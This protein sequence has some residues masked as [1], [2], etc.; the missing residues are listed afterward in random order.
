MGSGSSKQRL[1]ERVLDARKKLAADRKLQSARAALLKSASPETLETIVQSMAAAFKTYSPFSEPALLVAF[2]ANPEETQRILTKACKQVLSAP[3]IREQYEWFIRYVFASSVWMLPAS[4]KGDSFLFQEMMAIAQSM[5]QKIDLSMDSIFKHLASHDDWDK[6]TQIKDQTLVARQ[7]D[8]KVGL[9]RD[10]GITDL[11]NADLKQQDEDEDK[12]EGD[13]LTTFV[14]SNLAVNILTTTAKQLN[15]EF[16]AHIKPVMR[17]Y[18]D[19][20]EGP[21]KT[22]ERCQSKLENEYHDAEYPKAAKLLDLVRCSVSFN[23]LEQLLEGYEGLMRYIQTTSDSLELA[24]VKNGFLKKDVSFRDIKVHVVYHSETDPDNPVSMICEV[25]LI[26]NQYS[27]E[28][29]RIHKLY[30]ILR[31]RTY[32]EM[33]VKGS[34]DTKE[35]T[36]E[37]KDLQF[38]QVLN[39][40]EHRHVA[41]RCA[42]KHPNKTSGVSQ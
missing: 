37:L 7:D 31:E 24:C 40:K 28:K 13:D 8:D 3:I 19:F 17:R 12:Q 6:L 18:G 22:V 20:K 35:Q 23:T 1:G 2:E 15:P 5:S 29:K 14:D 34:D 10:Q 33:V 39:V 4:H 16:Q 21:T 26:L 42:N 41:T 25:Q 30:S 9:L 11:I 27:H 38:E 36:K 32:F